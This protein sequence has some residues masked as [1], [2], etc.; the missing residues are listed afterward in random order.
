[1]KRILICLLVILSG[2][3]GEV[4]EKI[5]YE[6]K[7]IT[8]EGSMEESEYVSLINDGT[9]DIFINEKGQKIYTFQEDEAVRLFNEEYFVVTNK[10]TEVSTF[11]DFH[12]Q[13]LAQL[14]KE[15]WSK[16]PSKVYPE[17]LY[18][19]ST[20]LDN[21]LAVNNVIYNLE[22]KEFIQPVEDN[23][24]Q[25][26]D[27]HIK[28]FIFQTH[29]NSIEK[30]ESLVREF[31]IYNT[32]LE[33]EQTLYNDGYMIDAN[34]SNQDDH[35]YVVFD[36]ELR[37]G[38]MNANLE[39]IVDYQY[40]DIDGLSF[41]DGL[42]ERVDEDGTRYLMTL[43]NEE[44]LKLG[45]YQYV[46]KIKEKDEYILMKRDKDRNVEYIQVNHNFNITRKYQNIGLL[47]EGYTLGMIDDKLYILKPDNT[48]QDISELGLEVPDW[49]LS[50]HQID[51]INKEFNGNQHM[52][53]R[54]DD[55]SFSYGFARLFY[56]Y[57]EGEEDV[58]V[59][60]INNQGEIIVPP[61]KAIR[62]TPFY[63][64]KK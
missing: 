26:Y 39:L 36:E 3:K 12:F 62:T 51:Y 53:P 9:K 63:K 14:T 17:D 10:N 32:D 49:S 38:V 28:K 37:A 21:K 59:A 33:L 50:K 18:L 47:E 54:T 4:V 25:L 57:G 31:R 64:M 27:G 5:T 29:K 60:Y 23:R 20:I 19:G 43:D 35:Y 16:Y 55:A 11:Y 6:V 48:L 30:K 40:Y 34:Y 56:A 24:R 52:V 41:Y 44:I 61:T 22:T 46:G 1:M 58:A 7:E 2:C 15:E 13:E 8:E 42:F 45:D